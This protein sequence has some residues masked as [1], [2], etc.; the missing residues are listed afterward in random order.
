MLMGTL[1]VKENLYFSAALR[2]PN[3]IPW[4]EKK[5]RVQS[6]IEDLGLTSCCNTK[7]IVCKY[8]IY[9]V[10][11]PRLTENSSPMLIINTLSLGM[12]QN[13][14]W[15]SRNNITGISGQ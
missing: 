11:S 10:S 9:Q 3:S 5:H 1:S 8:I 2:L 7:V 13:C 6:I 15:Q 4:N 14:Q 12:C